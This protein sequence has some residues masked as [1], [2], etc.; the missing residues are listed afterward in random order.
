[1]LVLDV[2][3]AP[4]DLQPPHGW[5]V[6]YGALGA[7]MPQP[8]APVQLIVTPGG[9]PVDGRLYAANSTRSLAYV[10]REDPATEA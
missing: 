2:T 8:D 5:V 9:E 3:E 7:L 6:P 10:A 4:I 1:M